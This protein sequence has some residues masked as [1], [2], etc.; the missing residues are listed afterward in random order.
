MEMDFRD[1]SPVDQSRIVYT[2]ITR[3]SQLNTNAVVY[4]LYMFYRGLA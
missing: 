3:Q 4:I 2:E 1:K